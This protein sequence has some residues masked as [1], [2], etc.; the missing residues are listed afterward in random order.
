ML[1][2]RYRFP[3]KFIRR[4]GGVIKYGNVALQA[5]NIYTFTRYKESDPES[6]SFIGVQQPV[7][8]M[9]LSMSF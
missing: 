2:L 3:Q 1:S 5:S 4:L 7:V 6:G 8:T 9:S